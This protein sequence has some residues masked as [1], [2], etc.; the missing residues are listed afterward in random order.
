MFKEETQNLGQTERE[1]LAQLL[2]ECSALVAQQEPLPTEFSLTDVDFIDQK[3]AATP[4]NRASRPDENDASPEHM[5]LNK[6][7]EER[8]KEELLI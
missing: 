3:R 5:D 4:E 8:R 7:R 6:L 1:F 2:Q